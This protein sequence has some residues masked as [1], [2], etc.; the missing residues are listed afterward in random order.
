MACL[1]TVEVLTTASSDCILQND[2]H[3][4]L[5][6]PIQQKTIMLLSDKVVYCHTVFSSDISKFTIKPCGRR[7]YLLFCAVVAGIA[8][9]GII[10]LADANIIMNKKHKAF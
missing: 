10:H 5:F 4:S 1:I 2:H 9:G 3:H 8:L 6:A 7:R